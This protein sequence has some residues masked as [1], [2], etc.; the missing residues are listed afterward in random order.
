[1]Q[2]HPSKQTTA[3]ALLGPPWLTLI[4]VRGE[5]RTRRNDDDMF[6]Q[7]PPR[8]RL[9]PYLIRST[10]SAFTLSIDRSQHPINPT[11]R[12][13]RSIPAPSTN[14][15]DSPNP[16]RSRWPTRERCGG[17]SW[18]SQRSPPASSSRALP[19]QHHHPSTCACHAPVTPTSHQ[20]P[21]QLPTSSFLRFKRLQNQFDIRGVALPPANDKGNQD[22]VTLSP[23]EAYFLG[24]AFATWLRLQ[25]VHTDR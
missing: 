14:S 15:I 7:T 9:R 6:N 5:G 8:F 19:S 1:M 17:Y 12:S 23:V 13:P 11:G 21:P 18:Y 10:A 4:C 2:S 22:A 24:Q 20:H 16:A 3:R 25:Q